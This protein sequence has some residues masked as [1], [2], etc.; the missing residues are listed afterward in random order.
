[1]RAGGGRD[2]SIALNIVND[3]GIN[4]GETFEYVQTRATR[5]ARNM[6]ANAYMTALTSEGSTLLSHGLLGSFPGL[7]S[8]A[9]NT[10]AKVAQP[11][12]VI[13]FRGAYLADIRGH[14]ADQLLIAAQYLDLA[15]L[16]IC[17]KCHTRWGIPLTRR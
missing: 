6:L 17:F 3:L 10:L 16:R 12:T 13:R 1:M 8:F 7:A 11:F 2:Q 9:A 14:L 15:G 4:A 5:R